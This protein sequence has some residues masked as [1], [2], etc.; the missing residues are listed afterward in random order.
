MKNLENAVFFHMSAI[1]FILEKDLRM[2]FGDTI[3]E[4]LNYENSNELMAKFSNEE[5]IYVRYS[6]HQDGN[7]PYVTFKI[8]YDKYT[9]TIKG[10][11]IK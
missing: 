4:P 2:Q 3:F 1:P 11:I 5:D 9:N 7:K 8:K 10:K 6:I